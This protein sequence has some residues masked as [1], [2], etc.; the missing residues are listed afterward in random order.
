MLEVA[1][2]SRTSSIQFPVK[3][4]L[5]KVNTMSSVALVPPC[6][7]PN[8][9]NP[10][11]GNIAGA[12]VPCDQT[13]SDC[14][15]TNGTPCTA[16]GGSVSTLNALGYSPAAASASQAGAVSASG[17]STNGG[18]SIASLVTSLGGV[19]EQTYQATQAPT[20]VIH[21]GA[22]GVSVP[23]AASSGLLIIGVLAVVLFVLSR[24]KTA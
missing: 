1:I 10:A 13:Q 21:L 20:N 16:A 14:V 17:A 8:G 23:V 7:S 22:N 24:K 18:T 5:E 15:D 2:S 19:A 4:T 9:D 12:Q 11:A 3:S 6:Y